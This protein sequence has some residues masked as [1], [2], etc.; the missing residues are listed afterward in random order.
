MSVRTFEDLSSQVK[1]NG[2]C[3]LGYLRPL[4]LVNILLCVAPDPSPLCPPQ[5]SYGLTWDRVRAS[6]P[7]NILTD[8]TENTPSPFT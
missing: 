5:T 2:P 1:E 8:R 6:V 3:C 4:V 7:R